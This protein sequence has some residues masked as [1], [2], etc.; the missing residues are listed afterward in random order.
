M[1]KETNESKKRETEEKVEGKNLASWM[2][3]Y[4]KSKLIC[5]NIFCRCIFHVMLF[6]NHPLFL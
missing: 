2:Q 4:D 6:F 3:L 1:D 5:T